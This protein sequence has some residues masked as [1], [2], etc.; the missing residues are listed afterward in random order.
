MLEEEVRQAA[1]EVPVEV[2]HPAG[3]ASVVAVEVEATSK[4]NFLV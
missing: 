2:A 3:P 1:S 4:T